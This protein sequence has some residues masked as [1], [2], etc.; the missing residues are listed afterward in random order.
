MRRFTIGRAVRRKRS[1]TAS[2]A[3]KKG[4]ALNAAVASEGDFGDRPLWC[5]LRRRLR[6]FLVVLSQK[7]FHCCVQ[8][9]GDS[10]LGERV[11]HKSSMLL[12]T[13]GSCVHP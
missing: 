1:A 6:P 4:E 13:V 3:A 10:R 5:Q 11:A 7:G 2:G 12:E 9:F 8:R